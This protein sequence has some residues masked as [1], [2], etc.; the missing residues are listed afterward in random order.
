MDGLIVK[1]FLF[2]TNHILFGRGIV[3]NII[4]HRLNI[5]QVLHFEIFP[6]QQIIFLKLLTLKG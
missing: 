1:Y 2:K 4:S 5:D 3:L 6:V